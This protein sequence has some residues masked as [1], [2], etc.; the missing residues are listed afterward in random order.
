L[1]LAKEGVNVILVARTKDEIECCHKAFFASKGSPL[2]PMLL[3][4]IGKQ[5]YE[6]HY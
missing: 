3:I 4:S 2:L 1:A 5:Q 6:K